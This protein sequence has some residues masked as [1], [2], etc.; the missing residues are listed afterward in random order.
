MLEEERALR[1]LKAMV[2][3]EVKGSLEVVKVGILAVLEKDNWVG[4]ESIVLEV[5]LRIAGCK[6]QDMVDWLVGKQR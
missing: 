6:G 4:N 1:R 5:G 2:L 3:I